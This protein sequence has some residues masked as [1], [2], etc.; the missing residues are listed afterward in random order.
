MKRLTPETLDEMR[1]AHASKGDWI[2]VG[3]STCGLAAGAGEVYSALVE[4]IQ[5]AGAKVAV[6]RAGCL[7]MCY[8]E[9]LVEVQVEGMPT[10]V[11]SHV[12]REAALNIVEKHIKGKRL[13]N[14]R[15]LAR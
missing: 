7:G 12:D 11:Y 6:K 13:V 9:P 10:V 8:A 15:I 2:K 1:A 5:K 14:D 4:E 3:M